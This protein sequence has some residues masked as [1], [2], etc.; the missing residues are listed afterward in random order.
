MSDNV[1]DVIDNVVEGDGVHDE[2]VK[3]KSEKPKE[4][5]RHQMER[6]PTLDED[7]K[8]MKERELRVN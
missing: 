1:R 5:G 3:R 7:R 6:Q 2:K 8:S 4:I